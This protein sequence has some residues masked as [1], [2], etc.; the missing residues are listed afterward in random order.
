VAEWQTRWLQVPVSFGT[1]GFKSPFA[2]RY[3]CRSETD[4][5]KTKNGWARPPL[6]SPAEVT[7]AAGLI[8]AMSEPLEWTERSENEH[9]AHRDMAHSVVYKRSDEKWRVPIFSMFIDASGQAEQKLGEYVL[10][11]LAHGKELAQA[12]ADQRGWT[13]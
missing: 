12:L 10:D 13:W 6:L 4:H 3:N 1:W 9:H 8:A 11:T 2:H 7:R 5:C